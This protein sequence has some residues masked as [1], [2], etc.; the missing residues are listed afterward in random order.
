MPH[1]TYRAV[2]DRIRAQDPHIDEQTL[3]DTVEGLTDLHEIVTAIIRSA[4]AD[5]ALATGLKSR[6]AEMQERLDRLQDRASKRRQIAKDVMVELDLKK[7]TAPD[8]SVSIRPGLPSLM[9][10]DEAAVPSIYWQPSAPRLKRQE[11]LSELKDG[12]EIDGVALSNP[13]PVLSVTGAVMGFSAKQLQALRRN[14]DGRQI[15]TRE[16]NGRELS[17]IEGWFAISEANRIF[18]FDGWSRETVESRCVLARENRGTFFAV[19]VAKVRITV[20]AD[21][22]TVVREGHGSGE[23][24]GTSPGE[25][26]DIALKAAETDATKRALATFGKPFG[27]ELYRQSRHVGQS[28]NA[29]DQPRCVSNSF[30]FSP[31]RYDTNSATV[32][33]LRPSSKPISERGDSRSPHHQRHRLLRLCRPP[34]RARLTK[35]F[36]PCP[37]RNAAGTSRTCALSPPSRASSADGSRPTPT[38]CA[39]AQPRAL[40]VKVSDEFTVPLCRGHHRQLH[41]AGNEVAWW[42]AFSIDVSSVARQLMGANPSQ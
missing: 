11:L 15:R 20:Q 24:R 27:L 26:H 41:Q 22:A 2:R 38:I 6:I 33:L 31:R 16:A 9:V 35:V 4:L 30:R 18:G 12:A 19:Y 36:S 3:A 23:G 25:V 34:R 37:N 7:I 21:G 42:E 17:Y 1:I 29:R 39:S 10:I 13:E 5:E 32:A 40:G 8:F 28:T 14:L